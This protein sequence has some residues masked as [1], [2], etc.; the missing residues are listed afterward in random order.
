MRVRRFAR[1]ASFLC[2]CDLRDKNRGGSIDVE[3][4]FYGAAGADW[5]GHAIRMYRASRQ[6]H[7]DSRGVQRLFRGYYERIRPGYGSGMTTEDETI[8]LSQGNQVQETWTSS[9][10]GGTKEWNSTKRLGE[11]VWHVVSPNKLS[12][13]SHQQQSVRVEV[14]EFHGTRCKASWVEKL[15]PGFH[16][17]RFYSISIQQDADFRQARMASST[18]EIISD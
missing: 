9:N 5:M 4:N 3:K 15:L 16:E 10:E 18:C 13:N 1:T 8:T 6:I 11:D 7:Q 2:I 12:K 17:Y 14:I